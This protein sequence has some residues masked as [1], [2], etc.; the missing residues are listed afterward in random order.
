MREKREIEG[1]ANFRGKGKIKNSEKRKSELH[2]A[3]RSCLYVFSRI[4]ARVKRI[5]KLK[6]FRLLIYF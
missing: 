4:G 6:T 3:F 5:I 2:L 1:H